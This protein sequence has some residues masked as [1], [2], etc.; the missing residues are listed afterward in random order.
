M[1][2]RAKFKVSWVEDMKGKDG[3]VTSRAVTLLP[4]TSD[5]EENRTFWEATPSGSLNMTI[6]NRAAFEQFARD[7]VFYLDFTPADE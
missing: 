2:V 1:A 5:S 7:Q 6:T 3:A 4:V